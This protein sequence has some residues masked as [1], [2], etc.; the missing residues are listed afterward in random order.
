MVF[1]KYFLKYWFKYTCVNDF[2][3]KMN[4]GKHENLRYE[5]VRSVLN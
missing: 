2:R 3:F 5:Q 4:N 1:Y